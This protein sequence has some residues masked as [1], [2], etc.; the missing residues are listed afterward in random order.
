MGRFYGKVGY[1]EQTEADGIWTNAITERQYT[2]D[3]KKITR[4]LSTADTLNDNIATSTVISVVADP[5]AYQ[6]FIKIVYVEWLDVK[7][8]ADS[9]DATSP[10]RLNIT[11]GGVYNG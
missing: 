3:V 11:L 5:Y 8:K 9:V 10:P 4:R 1:A 6:N 7:W 2:G